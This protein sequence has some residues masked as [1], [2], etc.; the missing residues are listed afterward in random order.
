MLSKIR[1]LIIKIKVFINMSSSYIGLVNTSM[2]LSLFMKDYYPN[3]NIN[4]ILL[5][6]TGI[7]FLIVTGYFIDKLGFFT[8]EKKFI[9]SRDPYIRKINMIDD[10]LNI[11]INK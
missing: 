3:L 9:S 1:L 5:I 6:V 8:T 11:I 10:K 4:P 7:I 2:I